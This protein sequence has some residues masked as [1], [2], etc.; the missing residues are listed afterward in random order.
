MCVPLRRKTKTELAVA[1]C[2]YNIERI[3]RVKN[4]TE[5]R[6]QIIIVTE[7]VTWKCGRKTSVWRHI[8]FHLR[9]TDDSK[10]PPP[11]VCTILCRKERALYLSENFIISPYMVTE[12]QDSLQ[13]FFSCQRYLPAERVRHVTQ[14]ELFKGHEVWLPHILRL[15][16][17]MRKSYEGV[18]FAR[19]R[20]GCAPI[21]RSIVEHPEMLK[22]P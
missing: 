10:W 13:D 19:R 22:C 1:Y 8:K 9:Y 3:L 11:S 6:H 20:I 2:M 16:T 14:P 17:E 18:A 7:L 21:P 15:W 5:D 12:F 4:T